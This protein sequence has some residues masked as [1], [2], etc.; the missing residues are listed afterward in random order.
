[1]EGYKFN[2]RDRAPTETVS[3]YIAEFRSL[4]E[5]CEFPLN[6]L[7]DMIKD[8]LVCGIKYNRIQ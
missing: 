5:H 1:M 2:E 7:N 6:V 3:T 4:T 8:R